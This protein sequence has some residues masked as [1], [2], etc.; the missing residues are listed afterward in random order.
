MTK[1]RNARQ[2]QG[3]QGEDTFRAFAG[4]HHLLPTRPDDDFGFDFVCFVEEPDHELTTK[5]IL[6][7][8]VGVSVRST[9][10][11]RVRL[12]RADAELLLSADFPVCVGLVRMTEGANEVYHRFLDADFAVELAEFLASGRAGLSLTPAAC[13]DEST[14]DDALRRALSG[15][16][17]ER[18][19][20]AVAEKRLSSYLPDA[21]IHVTRT[22]EREATLVRT[23]DFYNFFL[24][25]PE[26]S[27]DEVYSA[28]FGAP[29]LRLDRLAQ[30]GVR[31]EIEAALADLPQ[32]WL[33]G[34][35][36][37]DDFVVRASGA[38]G[39]VDLD[40]TKVVTAAHTGWVYEAGFSITISKSVHDGSHWVHEID[41]L[42]DAD[43][44]IGL[45]D[46]PQLWRFLELCTE[47][48][49]LAPLDFPGRPLETTYVRN[50]D[51]LN[52][53]ALGLRAA[54]ELD[55]GDAVAPPLAAALQDETLHTLAL[56][57][58]VAERPAFLK[59]F[60]YVIEGSGR[61]NTEELPTERVTAWVPIVGNAGGDAI[62]VWLDCE[63][64]YFV[65]SGLRCGIR[66]DEVRDVAV[67]V[68]DRVPKA[69]TYPEIV[70]HEGWPTVALEKG[71]QTTASDPSEWG[72]A[73][74]EQPS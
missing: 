38:G 3:R 74:V 1:R 6:G 45:E 20:L 66:I 16:S 57:R 59:G 14:F 11:Q 63:I 48:A 23:S 29:H 27:R 15:F 25:S 31:P 58:E 18:I 50:L 42:V 22:A 49:N 54:R 2:R 10:S 8:V 37:E 17:P 26:P 33:V 39:H 30:L 71:G 70:V 64:V 73:L 62:V 36:A 46:H 5:R 60:G 44:P 53:F 28:I 4:R 56:V 67:E 34:D 40:M 24:R 41:A 32:A 35:A 72:I 21:R 47:D 61:E 19:R 51:R 13:G 7:S 65:R 55:G 68:A 9:T 69:S 12:N 52:F 43:E